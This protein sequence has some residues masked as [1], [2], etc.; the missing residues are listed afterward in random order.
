MMRSHPNAA[1]IPREVL[2]VRD[3]VILAD[4][5]GMT[6]PAERLGQALRVLGAAVTQRL[7]ERR[8]PSLYTEFS[9]AWNA[10]ELLTEHPI[11]LSLSN[12][13]EPS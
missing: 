13:W 9:P 4:E 10:Q 2:L 3:A 7:K 6:A 11:V 1:E 12:D 5:Y 8:W